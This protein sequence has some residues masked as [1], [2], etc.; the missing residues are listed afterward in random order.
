L[1]PLVY[2]DLKAQIIEKY[3]IN[4]QIHSKTIAN[5]FVSV[6]AIRQAR[7]R[8]SARHPRRVSLTEHT[9]N[10]ENGKRPQRTTRQTP[11]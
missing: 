2:L 5:S 9:S 11:P 6:S 3:N 7:V 8:C 4:G 10:E 1:S